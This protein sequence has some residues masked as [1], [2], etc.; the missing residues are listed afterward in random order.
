MTDFDGVKKRFMKEPQIK[1]YKDI[2]DWS[3]DYNYYESC[4]KIKKLSPLIKIKNLLTNAGWWYASVV[5]G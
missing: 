2:D 3:A 4:K 1:D 5:S